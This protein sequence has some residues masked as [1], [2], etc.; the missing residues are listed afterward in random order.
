[1]GRQYQSIL[2]GT[3]YMTDVASMV[4]ELRR[5]GVRLFMAGDMLRWR[6][7]KG[8]MTPE[9]LE[10]LGRHKPELATILSH[11][12]PPTGESIPARNNT[13]PANPTA[14][15]AMTRLEIATDCLNRLIPDE[16]RRREIDRKA[17]LDAGGWRFL[18]PDYHRHIL[19]ENLLSAIEQSI[20][21]RICFGEFVGD[22]DDG[23]QLFDGWF[24]MPAP[25]KLPNHSPQ[26]APNPVENTLVEEK[27][28]AP[29]SK[30]S[31][32]LWN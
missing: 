30:V 1:M 11:N 24:L 2:R 5:Q 14:Y 18:G 29:I 3:L 26:K 13:E 7:P 19:S 23:D 12:P 4:T 22:S 8:V 15:S 31:G 28:T 16:Q 25:E 20:G 32:H 21:S 6:A 17:N 27:Q 10:F 9:M